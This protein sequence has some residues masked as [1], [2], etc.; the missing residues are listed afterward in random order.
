M[1]GA[2]GVLAVNIGVA[3]LFAAGYAVLALTHRAHRAALGFT[4]SYLLGMM[5]P[6]SDLIAPVVAPGGDG[7]AELGL[8]PGGHPVDFGHPQP[9]PRSP[10]VAGATAAIFVLGL[11]LRATIGTEPRDTIA[12][13]MAYQLPFTLAAIQATSTVLNVDRRPLHLALAGVFALLGVNFMVK[14]FLAVAFGAGRTLAGYTRTTYAMLS[15]SSSGLL[16]LAAGLVMLLIVAQK[17]IVQDRSWRRRPTHCRACP[18]GA[19][20]TARRSRRSHARCRRG[21]SRWRCS[22]S[23]TSSGSTTP[24]ATPWATVSSWPSPRGCGRWRR[25]APWP[26]GWAARSSCC[27]WRAPARTPHGSPR[28]SSAGTAPAARTYRPSRSAA[29]SPSFVRAR[30]WPS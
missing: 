12:Y 3:A 27:C 29:A 8:L 6:V 22:I 15:Q 10:R 20:S 13:G 7:V 24:S 26:G 2:E 19:A 21:P 9:V 25:R 30:A 11:A 14:P 16:L 4:I 5:S 18:T 28:T 17:A 23:T 1:S